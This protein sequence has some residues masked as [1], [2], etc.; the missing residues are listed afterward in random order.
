M[1]GINSQIATGGGGSG[2]VG[3]GFAVP[4]NTAKKLLPQLREGERHPARLPRREDGAGDRASSPTTST[5]RSNQGALVQSVVPGGPAAKAGPARRRTRPAGHPAGG[6]LIVEVDG[7]KVA[8]PDDVVA[9]IDDKK[10]GDKVEIEYYRGDDKQTATV[11]LAKRPAQLEQRERPEQERAAEHRSRTAA[12]R[13]LRPSGVT[14]VKI[15]GITRLDDAEPAS[16][17]RRVGARA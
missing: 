7:K 14:Q 4:I 15:C 3:I 11:K 8:D 10:P 17:A 2:S 16:R 5:C 12:S 9:A 1:I 13:R 6:D